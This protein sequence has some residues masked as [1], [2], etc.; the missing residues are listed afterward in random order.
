MQVR[1][2]QVISAYALQPTIKFACPPTSSA[3][4]VSKSTFSRRTYAAISLP[5]KK[6]VCWEEN[7]IPT[8]S[9]GNGESINVASLSRSSDSEHEIVHLHHLPGDESAGLLAVHKDG[10]VRY[11]SE[12]LKETRWEFRPPTSTL[13]GTPKDS[14][15]LTVAYAITTDLSKAKALL[16]N[17]PDITLPDSTNGG[18]VLKKDI[19]LFTVVRFGGSYYIR[20][21]LVPTERDTGNSPRELLSSTLLA[22]NGPAHALFSLNLQSATLYSLTPTNLITFSL[23]STAP[24]VISSLHLPARSTHH[25]PLLSLLIVSPSTALVATNEDISL[26]DTKFSSLQAHTTLVSTAASGPLAPGR[27]RGQV[28]LTTYV[29]DLDLGI[30]YSQTGIVGVQL[31]R[32]GGG[33]AQLKKSG[34]LIDSL[35]RGIEGIET[36]TNWVETATFPGSNKF[37]SRMLAQRAEDKKALKKLRAAKA[38]N[39]V[40]EFEET[41]ANYIG[42]ERRTDMAEDRNEVVVNGVSDLE[43]ATKSMADSEALSEFVP[44]ESGADFRKPLRRE[45]VEAVLDMIFEPLATEGGGQKLKMSFYPQNVVKYLVESG[46]FPEN[47]L[48]SG[49]GIA[50]CLAGFDSTLRALEWILAT[51][52]GIGVG[53]IVNAIEIAMKHKV[54]VGSDGDDETALRVIKSEVMRLALMRLNSFPNEVIIKSLRRGL[55]GQ[56][57]MTLIEL[58]RKELPLDK[59]PGDEATMAIGIEDVGIIADL[60]TTAL[61]TI[62]IGGLVLG[63]ESEGFIQELHGEIISAVKAAEEAACLKG[64]LEEMFRHADWRGMA[65]EKKLLEEA[66]AAR[67]RKS[68][69]INERRAYLAERSAIKEAR[70]KGRVREEAGVREEMEEK[71]QGGKENE[72]ILENEA[73]DPKLRGNISE[74]KDLSSSTANDQ[75]AILAEESVAQGGRPVPKKRRRVKDSKARQDKRQLPAKIVSVGRN[76]LDAHEPVSISASS[77]ASSLLPLG[78]LPPPVSRIKLAMQVGKRGDANP[79]SPNSLRRKVGKEANYRESMVAGVYSVE[80]MVV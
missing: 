25:S 48:G 5:K 40:N 68:D 4:R 46:N 1:S 3:T 47:L 45:F 78:V 60:L 14:G 69:R 18:G 55:E 26:Y 27:P 31:S 35:F 66:K 53:E 13:T 62:G 19:A 23:A 12:D 24:S 32:T 16:A 30:G 41:F 15:P 10:C 28:F 51:A 56:D 72:K 8:G 57:I 21:F 49:S 42:A 71:E 80:S 64:I 11:F 7:G 73:R 34:L 61:D 6:I 54:V 2:T 37:L 33:S 9:A 44:G 65:T 76:L 39:S 58:L 75:S 70:K 50:Q 29:Q 36:A 52:G 77:A 20:L 38:L 59:R 17:R 63:H 79:K 74:L 67:R 43:K 22:L